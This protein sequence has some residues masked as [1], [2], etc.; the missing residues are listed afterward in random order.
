M[1]RVLVFAAATFAIVVIEAV[2]RC[3]SLLYEGCAKNR[4]N[5]MK[6]VLPEWLHACLAQ[7]PG[8]TRLRNYPE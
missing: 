4:R 5:F 1:G 2:K 3:L 7:I 8:E 6:L